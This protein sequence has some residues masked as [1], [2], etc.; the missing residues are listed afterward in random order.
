LTVQKQHKFITK[1]LKHIASIR[2]PD[3]YPEYNYGYNKALDDIAKWGEKHIL[4]AVQKSFEKGFKRGCKHQ[5][6]ADGHLL[7]EI[8]ELEEKCRKASLIMAELDQNK[9]SKEEKEL[10]EEFIEEFKDF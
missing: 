2:K 4:K 10:I 5:A 1:F 3:I 6:F 7:E 8:D 9:L